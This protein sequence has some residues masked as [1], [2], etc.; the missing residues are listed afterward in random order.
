MSSHNSSYAHFIHIHNL[1]ETRDLSMISS[2]K[3]SIFYDTLTFVLKA[4][5]P[6]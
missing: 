1:N 2:L 6:S 5:T 3:P 4:T